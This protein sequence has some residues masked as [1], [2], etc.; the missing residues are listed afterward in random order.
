MVNFYANFNQHFSWHSDRVGIQKGS[1]VAAI[2]SGVPRKT[3]FRVMKHKLNSKDEEQSDS[4]SNSDK[5]ENVENN[6]K[7]N[8]KV[9]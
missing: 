5:D 8:P 9:R 1:L 3:S 2:K 6:C 4:D 7:L